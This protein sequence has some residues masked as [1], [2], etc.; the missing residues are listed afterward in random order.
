MNGVISIDWNDVEVRAGFHSVG[1]RHPAILIDGTALLPDRRQIPIDAR[2]VIPVPKQNGRGNRRAEA[3][4]RY[5]ELRA[6]DSRSSNS[7]IAFQVGEEFGVCAQSILNWVRRAV[8]G[9]SKALADQYALPKFDPRDEVTRNRAIVVCA[10]WA[11]RI[12]NLPKIDGLAVRM[13]GEHLV[14]GIKAAD[15]VATIDFYFQTDTDRTK[16]PFKGLARWIRY[17]LK[18][19]MHRAAAGADQYRARVEAKERQR[20]VADPVVRRRVRKLAVDDGAASPPSAAPPPDADQRVR[21]GKMLERLGFPE[22]GAQV[23]ATALAESQRAPATIAEGLHRMPAPLRDAL[24]S[25]ASGGK[26]ERDAAAVVLPLIWPHLPVDVTENIDARVAAFIAEHPGN[27]QV[28]NRRKL[29]M[30]IP[31][32]KSKSGIERL[33]VALRLPA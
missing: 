5:R 17:D 30:L 19:W 23:T 10:W 3:V 9:G 29:L 4:A 22:A 1:Q 32:V 2:L 20:A 11:Y 26:E 25:A 8:E 15:I 33:G 28:A 16:F 24:L 18:K 21:A 7:D 27:D 6:A 14:S 12:R 13:V 31:L